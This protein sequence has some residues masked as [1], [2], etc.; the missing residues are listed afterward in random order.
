MKIIIF[1]NSGS[2]KSTLSKVLATKLSL[3]HL[4]LDTISWELEKPEIRLPIE[5]SKKQLDEFFLDNHDWVIEG[6]YSFLISHAATQATSV[7]FLNQ[8]MSS[9][10]ENAKRRPWE[11]HKYSTK[12]DQDKN[13]KIL[14]DWIADY[15]VRGDEY[16]LK[17]HSAIYQNFLNAKFELTSNREILDF[18][19]EVISGS[20]K[21]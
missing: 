5:E 21:L 12:K 2:G 20:I 9:C 10:Q 6:C 14:L 11:P 1:G 17:Q 18:Q 3:T 16:S 13:L 4:D 8:T 15:E 7:V 19:N